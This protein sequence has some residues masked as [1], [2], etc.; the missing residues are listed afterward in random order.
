MCRAYIVTGCRGLSRHPEWQLRLRE[1]A[2]GHAA[3]APAL[4][5]VAREDHSLVPSER[6]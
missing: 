1:E 5:E 2:R 3:L 4:A 6:L